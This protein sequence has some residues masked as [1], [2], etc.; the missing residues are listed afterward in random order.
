[1]PRYAAIDIGSNSI[2]MEAAEVV[3]GQPARVL[4]S[5]REVTRLG[6][7]VFRTGSVGEEALKATCAV[8]ARMAEIHRKLD[9]VGVRAVATSAIRDSGNQKAF[10]ARASEAVGAPVE[11]ISGREEARLI[12]LGVESDWPQ[13]A[14]RVLIVDIGGGSAEI[15]AAE[16]GRLRESFSKPLGA[17]RLRE[18]FL[19]DD[20]PAPLQLHQMREYIQA[21]L[22]TAVRRLGNSG[23]DRAIATSATA[24]A[25]ASAIARVPRSQRDQIDRLRVPTAQVRKLYLKLAERNLAGRRKITGI[26]PR[27]AEIV[28][29][30]VAVLLEFLQEFHLPAVYYS[31]A[32]VRDG[33][34][35]D[36]AAR[37]V[38]AELSR[39]TRDQRREVEA[40][41]RRYGVSLDHA[42]K[43][44]N[45]S[46]LLFTALQPCTRCRP[47]AASSWRPPPTCTT[48]DISSAIP[49]ITSIPGTWS[50]TPTWPASPSASGSSSPACAAITASPS[51]TRCTPRTCRF[52]RKKGVCC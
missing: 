18:I 22:D 29:P 20:P 17:V 19:K 44:A 31:R 6:E 51:P 9:V 10:L 12:H 13:Q 50:P 46:N 38:G 39:L 35:A 28:V 36:L 47:A 40:M 24:S 27:R 1:M 21:K 45:I 15:V 7:S 52:R 23:W 37:N 16:A 32:G 25:V 33:I 34:I 26:G 8:L 3:P 4:A 11:I 41:G 2:R 43:V 14:R 49:A 42:R 5:E 30:G 48:W